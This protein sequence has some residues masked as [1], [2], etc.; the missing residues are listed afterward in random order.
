MKIFFWLLLLLNDF[1]L[2]VKVHEE[3]NFVLY[4]GKKI[5]FVDQLVHIFVPQFQVD[6]QGFVIPL[7]ICA[8]I[9]KH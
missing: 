4:G 8:P 7:V 1:Y 5:V 6:L 9:V 2:F 3:N